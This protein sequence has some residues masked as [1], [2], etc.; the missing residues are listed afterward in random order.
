M[1]KSSQPIWKRTKKNCETSQ[2]PKICAH[3]ALHAH[4][5]QQKTQKITWAK[6]TAG[7]KLIKEKHQNANFYSVSGLS[8]PK[9]SS[10]KWKID[11]ERERVRVR[12]HIINPNF[13]IWFVLIKESILLFYVLVLVVVLWMM[14]FL[15][16]L[17]S[18]CFS[19][20]F[21]A[22]LFDTVRVWGMCVDQL[23]LDGNRKRS[24]S[25]LRKT[26]T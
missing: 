8:R 13:I 9:F 15:F 7:K 11:G 23:V 25:C 17:L 10:N 16:F 12:T 22:V 19:F 24:G 5:E 4:K 2:A 3:T 18:L 20:S 26:R 21:L 1:K 6:P 14:C